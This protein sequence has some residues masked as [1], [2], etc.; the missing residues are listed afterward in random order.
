M[1]HNT[2]AAFY[3]ML[4]S[5][6]LSKKKKNKTKQNQ[7]GGI[8]LT[9]GWGNRLGG[10]RWA[11][12][13]RARKGSLNPSRQLG[14]LLSPW[15]HGCL[16][17]FQL[18]NSPR[19]EHQGVL[20]LTSIRGVDSGNALLRGITGHKAIWRL[21]QQPQEAAKAR[22]RGKLAF[23]QNF[24]ITVLGDSCFA[25]S[26]LGCSPKGAISELPKYATYLCTHL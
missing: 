6:S 11:Q 3:K 16:L 20:H 13:C 9:Y 23:G 19:G 25:V 7:S 5:F 12:G 22:H 1:R 14:S 17:G 2:C 4:V 15:T 8:I 24:G 21:R 10:K 26:D 18:S